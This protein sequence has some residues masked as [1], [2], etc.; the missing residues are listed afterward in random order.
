MKMINLGK[1]S[2]YLICTSLL[3]ACGASNISSSPN[4]NKPETPRPMTVNTEKLLNTMI[5][6]LASIRNSAGITSTM[7][8]SGDA[9][10]RYQITI[11][12]DRIF[13]TGGCNNMSGSFSRGADNSLSV[14]PMMGTKR[15]CMGT[16]MQSDAE[17]SDYLSRV[18]SYSINNQ[19]LTLK[20][21]NGQQLNFSGSPTDEAKYGSKGVRK[22]IELNSTAKG[23]EWREVKYDSRWIRLKDD[24][25]WQSNFPGIQ[26]FTPKMNMHYIVRLH[27]YIDPTTKKVVWVK[28]MVTTSG[29]LR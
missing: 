26:G 12:N 24:A 2:I 14:G 1:A 9:A 11:N 25:P 28:D 18:T 20:T 3:T 5:W 23:I 22:F 4:T 17:I 16:L 29:I 13:I 21:E 7:L 19:T 6:Q 10:S 8:N 27:E 15:A